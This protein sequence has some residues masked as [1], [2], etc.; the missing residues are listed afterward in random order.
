MID[1]APVSLERMRRAQYGIGLRIAGRAG[2]QD[3]AGPVLPLRAFAG[4]R[5]RSSVF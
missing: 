2:Q 3:P 5:L 4:V 1:R